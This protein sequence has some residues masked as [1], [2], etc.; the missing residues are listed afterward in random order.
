MQPK[1]GERLRIVSYTRVSTDSQVEDGFGLDVQE[2]AITRW[3]RAHGHRLTGAYTDEGISGALDAF[4]REGL[5]CAIEAIESGKAKA[6]LVPRLDR[7]ARR[8]TV[9]EAV[10]AHV[11]RRGG[12]VFTVETGEV[13]P[14][15]PN[16][17]MRTAMRQ[18]MGVFAELDRGQIAKR[19]RDGRQ[20]KAS[21][22]GYAGGS[23]PYG[24]KAEG[25][26]LVADPAEQ[27][28]VVRMKELRSEG[29][30]LRGI[31]QALDAQ[32]VRS[33]R[34]AKWS[35]STIARTIDPATRE[36]ARDEARRRRGRV[37]A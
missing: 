37:G 3:V 30:S 36:R 34:G 4:D 1:S 25:R 19:L 18:M 8:L 21:A 12:R 35:P 24:W 16:D 11:W 6:L 7:L 14:D 28:V 2:A 23:P 27:A 5:S 29:V 33:K 15:D 31:A 26:E 9:Q 22:G 20:A 32:G 17:P 10:L 13:L